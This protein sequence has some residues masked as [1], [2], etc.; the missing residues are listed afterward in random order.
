VTLD[1]DH[2]LESKRETD[3]QISLLKQD[4][5]DLKLQLSNLERALTVESDRN[6]QL[7]RDIGQVEREKVRSEMEKN[8]FKQAVES[9]EARKGAERQE[10]ELQLKQMRVKHQEDLNRVRTDYDMSLTQIKQLHEKDKNLLETMLR[11]CEER[12]KKGDSEQ[13][14]NLLEVE[15]K[16]LRDIRNLNDSFD[17]YKK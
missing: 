2:L 17:A 15:N 7:V 3:L 9:G 14:S 4:N 5:H 13:T 12:L 16:Y 10:M 1:N 8:E 6:K 11:K